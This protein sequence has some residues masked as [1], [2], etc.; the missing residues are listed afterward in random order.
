[1]EAVTVKKFLAVFAVM[2]AVVFVGKASAQD[3]YVGSAD[4]L[5]F[6][7]NTDTVRLMNSED[8]FVDVKEYNRDRSLKTVN[9]W[10]FYI[11]KDGEH[12]FF[13]YYPLGEYISVNSNNIALEILSNCQNYDSRI[14]QKISY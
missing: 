5:N 2:F 1:L 7:V 10:R 4:G 13:D 6:Y 9:E 8:F 14:S 3:I 11:G 12:W